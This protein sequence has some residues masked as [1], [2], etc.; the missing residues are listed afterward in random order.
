MSS[1]VVCWPDAP[2]H[3][4]RGCSLGRAARAVGASNATRRPNA[5]VIV[6]S[7][8]LHYRGSAEKAHESSAKPRTEN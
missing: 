3:L 6:A 7:L 8:V 1:E 5:E 2:S 4:A